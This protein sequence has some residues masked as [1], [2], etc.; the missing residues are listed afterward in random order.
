MVTY[1]YAHMMYIV[2]ELAGLGRGILWWPPAYSLFEIWMPFLSSN[3]QSQ[4][5]VYIIYM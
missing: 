4:C 1:P 2:S 5:T 3:E